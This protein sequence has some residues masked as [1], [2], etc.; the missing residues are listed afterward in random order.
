MPT[1]A[2]L[3]NMPGYGGSGR[4]ECRM[5]NAEGRINCD[6]ALDGIYRFGKGSKFSVQSSALNGKKADGGK[7]LPVASRAGSAFGRQ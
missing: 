4:N 7:A 3:K 1:R 6:R 5:M 2:T